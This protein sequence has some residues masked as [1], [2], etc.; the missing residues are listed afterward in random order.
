MRF[1]QI[2]ER[3]NNRRRSSN[4]LSGPID[5]LGWCIG[6]ITPRDNKL[7]SEPFCI[8]NVSIYDDEVRMRG[9]TVNTTHDGSH[10]MFASSAS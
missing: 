8:E 3:Q 6:W 4:L 9:Y 7:L 1:T 5:D 2:F 10:V